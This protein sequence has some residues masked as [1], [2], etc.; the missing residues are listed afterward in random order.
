M[1][2]LDIIMDELHTRKAYLADTYAPY[3]VYSYAIH[4]FNLYNQEARIYWEGGQ[5]P[6]MRLSILFVAPS[7]FMKTYYLRQMGNKVAGIFAG[8]KIQMG[9]E[10][11]LTAAGLVGTIKPYKDS[12]QC[13]DI[14]VDGAAKIYQKAI[15]SIDEFSGITNAFQSTYNNQMDSQLL[16]ILDSGEVYKHLGG[17]KIEYMTYMTLWAGVQP[18]RYDLRSGMGRRML[19]LVF[20]PSKV[21]NTNL[22]RIQQQAHNIEQDKIR[23]T[24]IWNEVNCWVDDINRIERVEFD[25]SLTELYLNMDLFSFEVSYF[26]RLALGYTLATEGPSR[27]MCIDAHASGL[28]DMFKQQ[29]EWRTDIMIGIDQVQMTKLI[30]RG[31]VMNKE[32]VVIISR[33]QLVNDCV[34]VG[35]NAQQVNEKLLELMKQGIV[36]I[37]GQNV[38]LHM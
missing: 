35:W 37:T 5:L 6:N 16:S 25:E 33:R 36:K 27:H 2:I 30:C 19:F 26:N 14:E 34:M 23:M 4:A 11:E 9:F 13:C 10:Q 3:Y 12:T 29:K 20:I 38:E 21:D 15:V 17:G 32:G 24:R 28:V 8:A 22:I 31:G 7:G 18:A 1:S